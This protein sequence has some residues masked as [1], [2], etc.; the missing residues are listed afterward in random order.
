MSKLRPADH[1][2]QMLIEQGGPD[3]DH[4]KTFFRLF[5]PV[6]AAAISL[7]LA[8]SQAI[9][10]SQ[11]AEWAARAFLLYG[12]SPTAGA[13]GGVPSMMYPHPQQVGQ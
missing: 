7:I 6:E 9:Q 2:R 8:T 11:I 12:G 1:L 10:D 3:N 4:V 5:G 13:M